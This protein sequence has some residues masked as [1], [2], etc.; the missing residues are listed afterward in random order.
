MT[1]R[2]AICRAEDPIWLWQPA[3]PDDA[4]RFSRAFTWP[5]WQ[6]RGFLAVP[7][8]DACKERIQYGADVSFRARGSAWQTQGDELVNTTAKEAHP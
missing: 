3:G 8:Y 1:R 2:C 6:T 7:C 5:G 4:M